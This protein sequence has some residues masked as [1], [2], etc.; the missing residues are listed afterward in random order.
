MI[1]NIKTITN[2]RKVGGDYFKLLYNRKSNLYLINYL[3]LFNFEDYWCFKATN[4]PK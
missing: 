2:A 4:Q 3:P 1:N